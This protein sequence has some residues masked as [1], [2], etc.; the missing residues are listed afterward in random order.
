[1]KYDNE[2]KP[3]TDEERLK[4]IAYISMRH[5]KDKNKKNKNG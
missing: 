4:L 1:M 3:K 5:F 2:N